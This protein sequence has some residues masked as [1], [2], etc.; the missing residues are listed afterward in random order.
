MQVNLKLWENKEL[1]I[2]DKVAVAL[3]NTYN[4]EADNL[5]TYV[6]FF[7]DPYNAYVGKEEESQNSI[8]TAYC[9]ELIDK[10]PQSF[11]WR[12]HGKRA[13]IIL[14]EFKKQNLEVLELKDEVK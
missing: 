14:E 1:R 9:D 8:I 2:V 10:Q 5:R 4:S 11:A 13:E 7:T 12:W 6:G 3:N